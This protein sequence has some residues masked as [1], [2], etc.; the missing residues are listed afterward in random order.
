MRWEEQR[1]L[2]DRMVSQERELLMTKGVEYS[3]E[4]DSLGNFK[5]GAADVDLD[6]KKILWVYMS[7][8]L[9]SIK[10]F[11]RNGDVIS[12]ETIEG[13]I[14]DARNYLFLLACLIEDEGRW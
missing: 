4:G 5:R 6:P 14:A 10:Y 11:I 2:F 8:H 1:E 7:K 3:G 9:D 13:R 12:N